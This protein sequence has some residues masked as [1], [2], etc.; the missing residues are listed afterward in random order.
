[1]PTAYIVIDDFESYTD[2]EPDVV[3]NTWIDGQNIPTN[4]SSAGYPIGSFVIGEGSYLEDEI[5][6]SGNWSLPLFYDNSVGLSE[7]AR[8][9][10]TTW[11]QYGAET[12]TLWYHG[13]KD[14]DAE[15]MYVAVNDAVVTNDDPDA[16]LV[17]EWIRWDIPLQAFVDQGVNFENVDTMSIGF[18][19]KA[20]PMPG[21]AGHVFFD[22]IRLYLP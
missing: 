20:E 1:L 12:L 11:A 2:Y 3:W 17:D 9:I 13:V 22:D 16:A 19:N 6:H 10:N 7:V 5:V 15:P 14:N 18:G 4:G 8:A 21:G